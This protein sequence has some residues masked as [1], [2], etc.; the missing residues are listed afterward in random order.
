MSTEITP[1]NN[2]VGFELKSRVAELTE[3]LLTKHPRMPLLLKEIHTTLRQYP[4][5][6]TLL[7]ESEIN[8]I[9]EGLKIQTQTNFAE[10]KTKKT[11]GAATS[12]T[13]KIKSL[14]IGAF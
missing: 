11:G 12:T 7:D 14:G 4:E 10:S 6:V 9:V 13:A 1:Q 5:N 3:A 2:P 8:K